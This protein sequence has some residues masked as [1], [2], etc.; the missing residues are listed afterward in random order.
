M[1]RQSEVA[2]KVQNINEV[3]EHFGIQQNNADL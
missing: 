2:S 1:R 3:K